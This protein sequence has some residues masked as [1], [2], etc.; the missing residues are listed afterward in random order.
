MPRAIE[1]VR[2]LLRVGRLDR[3]GETLRGA[4]SACAL[5]E[6]LKPRRITRG[7][8]DGVQL[9]AIQIRHSL[10]MEITVWFIHCTSPA[11]SIRRLDISS[12]HERSKEHP[13]ANGAR[14]ALL[15]REQSH[16]CA[17]RLCLMWSARWNV[18]EIAIRRASRGEQIDPENKEQD[19]QPAEAENADQTRRIDTIAGATTIVWRWRNPYSRRH[20]WPNSWRWCGR[21]S[22]RDR[23]RRDQRG[24]I[25]ATA[26][27]RDHLQEDITR[28]GG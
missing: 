15:A 10:D 9:I 11:L 23:L 7:G 4:R 28:E 13:L 2:R 18:S 22:N 19:A 25:L 6:R 26:I 20:G 8:L 5:V 3:S 16:L 27:V 12:S 1:H 17:R 24:Q 14:V 21:L